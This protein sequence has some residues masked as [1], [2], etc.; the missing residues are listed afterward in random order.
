MEEARLAS[1]VPKFETEAQGRLDQD[2]PD[3]RGMWTDRRGRV[4]YCGRGT[5][6]CWH[7]TREGALT[8]AMRTWQK[9]T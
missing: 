2:G 8:C 9:P 5:G 6:E 4:M 7:E 3:Y 1:G